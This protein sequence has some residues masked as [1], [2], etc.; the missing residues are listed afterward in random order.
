MVYDLQK[1]DLWKRISAAL[2]DLVA[3]GMLIVAIAWVLSSV[4]NYDTYADALTEIEKSYAEKYDIDL[5]LYGTEEYEKLPEEVKA[6]YELANKM[7]Q[8]DE[9]AKILYR[10]KIELVIFMSVASIVL[11]FTIL[12]FVVPL[13]LKN[14][15]TFGKK[16]FGICVIRYDLVKISPLL[17]FVRSMLGQCTVETLLP[18]LVLV[19]AFTG[20]GIFSLIILAVYFIAQIGFILVTRERTL[21]HDIMAQTVVVDISS[22]MIF[23]TPEALLEYKQKLQAE[24]AAKSDY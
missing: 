22:Q 9:Q 5:N 2:F 12:E 21:I 17:L 16:M 24:K 13:I 23:E 19:M 3:M 14:G 1:A 10:V 4:T 11:G 18:A 15:Q 7:Y 8:Q 20:G 6:R